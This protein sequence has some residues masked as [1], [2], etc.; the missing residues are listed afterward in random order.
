VSQHHHEVGIAP[1]PP[2]SVRGNLLRIKQSSLLA[3]HSRYLPPT[4]SVRLPPC[5]QRP[6][7]PPRRTRLIP[8]QRFVYS[9]FYSS[10]F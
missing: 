9:P 6:G 7:N 8:S 3:S 5:L 10:L 2:R 4:C 1:P